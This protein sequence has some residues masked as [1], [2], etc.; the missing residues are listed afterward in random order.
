MESSKD[1]SLSI[2]KK[3]T[4][5]KENQNK[6]D[7]LVKLLLIIKNLFL[8]FINTNKPKIIEK[9]TT[10]SGMA[11]PVTKNNGIN[12][13]KNINKLFNALIIFN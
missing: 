4:K 7:I 1:L 13:S 3:L 11:G 9:V 8:L 6:R 2:A 5:I 10:M 12:K